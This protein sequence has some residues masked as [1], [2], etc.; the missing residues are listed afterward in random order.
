M[1]KSLH[2]SYFQK[3]RIFLYPLLSIPR[4]TSVTP[5]NTYTA[6]EGKY[7]HTDYRLICLYHLRDDKEFKDFEKTRLFSNQ[8]FEE[9]SEVEDNKGI[10]VFNIQDFKN[11]IDLFYKGQYSKFSP[12]CKTCILDHFVRSKKNFVHVESYLNPEMYYATYSELLECDEKILKSVGELCSIPDL[13][14]ETSKN[15]VQELD[16]L[17]FKLTSS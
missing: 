12:Y 17:K 13:E 1:I 11:D 2:N 8:Y 7:D 5:I 15:I 3:S 4:G 14:K 9:F 10:Y 16:Y 6:W